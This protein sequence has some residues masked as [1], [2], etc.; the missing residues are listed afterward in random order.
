MA[1][2]SSGKIKV[3][4]YTTKGVSSFA[5]ITP[6]HSRDNETWR[7]IRDGKVTKPIVAYVSADTFDGFWSLYQAHVTQNPNEDRTGPLFL[8][9]LVSTLRGYKLKTYTGSNG[10]LLRVLKNQNGEYSVK[11]HF[12]DDRI[13]VYDSDVQI[14]ESGLVKLL[15]KNAPSKPK[16]TEQDSGMISLQE[17]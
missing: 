5:R 7:Y 11:A 3:E 2:S 6:H 15:L 8:R 10:V 1:E 16:S 17:K 4:L 13:V 14:D 12:V 9:K